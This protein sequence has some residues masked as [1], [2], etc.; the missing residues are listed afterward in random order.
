MVRTSSELKPRESKNYK[1]AKGL[2]HRESEAKV[3]KGRETRE[4]ESPRARGWK[5]HSQERFEFP[6]PSQ[7]GP[8]PLRG[9][10]GNPAN[11]RRFECISVP[12]SLKTQRSVRGCLGRG[13]NS[14]TVLRAGSPGQAGRGQELVSCAVLAPAPGQRPRR[15]GCVPEDRQ[16]LLWQWPPARVAP[17]TRR[18]LFL[19][20]AKPGAALPG[21]LPASTRRPGPSMCGCARGRRLRAGGGRRGRQRPHSPAKGAGARVEGVR[22]SAGSVALPSPGLALRRAASGRRRAA[23]RWFAFR[24]EAIWSPWPRCCWE[25]SLALSGRRGALGP[26]RTWPLLASWRLS[27]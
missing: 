10:H 5:N 13:Y 23:A 20:P 7:V 1:K 21:R 14:Q 26:V 9:S 19:T 17:R 8:Q 16:Q 15:G 12:C 3:P 4:G 6:A 27:A 2:N 24:G 18:R 25:S 11:P 22:A